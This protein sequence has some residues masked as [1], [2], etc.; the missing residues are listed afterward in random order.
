MKGRRIL[1]KFGL[2]FVLFFFPFLDGNTN[3]NLFLVITGMSLWYV[4]P[5]FCCLKLTN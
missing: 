1:R 2:L 4:P 3:F 5:F